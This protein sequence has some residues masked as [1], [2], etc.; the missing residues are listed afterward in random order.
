MTPDANV[1]GISVVDPYLNVGKDNHIW[2][3][4]EVG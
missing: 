4:E 3:D 2:V 1:G